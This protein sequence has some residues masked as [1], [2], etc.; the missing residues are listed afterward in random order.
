MNVH[1]PVVSP[2]QVVEILLFCQKTLAPAV[3]WGLAEA[4]PHR[5][6]RMLLPELQ[7][8][9]NLFLGKVR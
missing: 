3:W 2:T 4:L 9:V 5:C 7:M 8:Q 6:G 1:T